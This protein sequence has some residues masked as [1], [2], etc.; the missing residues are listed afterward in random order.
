MSFTDAVDKYEKDAGKPHVVRTDYKCKAHGCPNAA[1][2]GGDIC[3][4]HFNEPDPLKWG[5]VTAKVRNH[6]ETMR[7]YGPQRERS[8][9]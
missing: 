5:A 4:W 3:Y 7:N 2:M 9:Q 8:E 6:F 1:T